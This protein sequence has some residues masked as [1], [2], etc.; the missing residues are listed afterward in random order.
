MPAAD[1][2]RLAT[3]RLLLGARVRTLRTHAGLQL[4]D[5][6]ERAGMSLTFL[7]EMERGRKLPSLLTLDTVAA[8]LGMT[9]AELLVGVYPWGS[10][11]PPAEA[12]SAPPDGRAGRPLADTA[13]DASPSNE[14]WLR[15][16]S[17]LSPRVSHVTSRPAYYRLAS[18]HDSHNVRQR[19]SPSGGV[20]GGPAMGAHHVSIRAS[21]TASVGRV[22]LEPTTQGL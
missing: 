19:P 9:A 22:G 14:H 15:R 20:Q 3:G 18:R 2:S 6:A 10:T 16:T 1:E 4:A 8:A 11:Q 7:S 17:H 21:G 13:D 12:P 5:L